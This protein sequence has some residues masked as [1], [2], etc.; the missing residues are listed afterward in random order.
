MRM[1]SN[2]LEFLSLTGVA[3]IAQPIIERVAARTGELARLSLVD[4]EAI[5]WVGKADGQRTGFVTIPIWARQHDC[6]AHRRDTHGS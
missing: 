3:D 5:I 4:G 1:T 2:G 6:P